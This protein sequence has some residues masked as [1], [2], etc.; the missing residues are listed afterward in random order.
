MIPTSIPIGSTRRP[1]GQTLKMSDDIWAA[2]KASG[3]EWRRSPPRPTALSARLC[4]QAL[5]SG[6]ILSYSVIRSIS[7]RSSADSVHPAAR[8]F[9]S[10]CSGVVAPAMT[11][12]TTPSRSNQLNA[13]SSGVTAA[14]DECLEFT[15]DAPIALVDEFLGVAWVLRQPRSW[16]QRRATLVLAGQQAAG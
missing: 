6:N 12:A 9:C 1:F 4:A 8:T 10:T 7:A 13:S 2:A 16:R 11:L 14:C 15:D 3:V 5:A